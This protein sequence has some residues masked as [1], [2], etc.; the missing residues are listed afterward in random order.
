MRNTDL[1]ND[2]QPVLERIGSLVGGY[3]QVVIAEALGVRQSSI[4]DAKKR[5]CIPAAWLLTLL[6]TH[7]VNPDWLVTGQGP[8]YLLPK[9]AQSVQTVPD[10]HVLSSEAMLSELGRRLEKAHT[11]RTTF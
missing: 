4:S 8:Q 7:S 11:D 10:M 9:E 3:T 5:G 1:T 6:R 2:I